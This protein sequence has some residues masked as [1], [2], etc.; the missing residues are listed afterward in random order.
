MNVVQ[1]Q[2]FAPMSPRLKEQGREWEG[3]GLREGREGEG[4]RGEGGW[5]FTI[6]HVL[7]NSLIIFNGGGGAGTCFTFSL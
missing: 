3:R 1:V 5:I 4:G 2:R 6:I 7:T